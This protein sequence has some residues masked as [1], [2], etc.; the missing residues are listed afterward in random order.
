MKA[1]IIEDEAHAQQELMR[2]LNKVDPTITVVD[3]IPSIR[4]AVK[5]FQKHEEPDIIFM[6]IMLSDGESF[7]I[8]KQ[9][10]IQSPIIFTTAYN[11]HALKA[12]RH[13]SIDYLLK[14]VDPNDLRRSLTKLK[15]LTKKLTEKSQIK[16]NKEIKQLLAQERKEYKNRFVVRSGDNIRYI[17]VP[18]INWF[19]SSNEVVYMVT[20]DNKKF[21]INYTL[22]ELQ[23]VLNPDDF[24]RISRKYI[25]KIGSVAKVVKYFGSRLKIE[26]NPPAQDEILISRA[27]VSTFLGW[28]EK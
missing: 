24:F 22:D 4:E 9:V 19:Y 20:H 25:A 6:D 18:D 16:L 10:E 3:A 14:P 13:N 12:F 5:W 2:L 28:L 15:N 21:V 23:E 1:L 17:S 26:L 27:R 8:L 11:E 7:E